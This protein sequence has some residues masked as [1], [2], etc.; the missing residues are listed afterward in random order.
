MVGDTT[1]ISLSFA[2]QQLERSHDVTQQS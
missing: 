2:I 1:A